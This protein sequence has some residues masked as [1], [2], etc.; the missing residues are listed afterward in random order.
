METTLVKDQKQKHR[1]DYLD[2]EGNP[3]TLIVTIRH[4]DQCGNGHNT[5]S[6]TTECYGPHYRH[7]EP[8]IIHKTPTPNG[9]IETVLW[10]CS[11]GCNHEVVAK[12]FPNLAP[13]IKWHLCSPDGP[14]HYITNSLYWAGKNDPPNLKHFQSTAIW[15]E[16]DKRILERPTDWLVSELEARLPNLMSE[17]QKAVESL[18]LVY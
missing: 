12:R 4:D 1:I 13:Y 9:W 17:F 14:L 7:G 15:P 2:E 10:M 18:G 16:A 5:F 11:C 3:E 8:T 6:I